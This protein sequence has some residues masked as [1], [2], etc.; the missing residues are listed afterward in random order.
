MKT[1]IPIST[2]A[3]DEPYLFDTLGQLYED[4]IVSFWAYIPHKGEGS[5]MSENKD[6]QHVYVELDEKVKLL[7]FKDYF[8][9]HDGTPFT[10]NWRKSD[11]QN[12][13]WYVLHDPAYLESKGIYREY[14]YSIDDFIVSDVREFDRLFNETEVPEPC[15]VRKAIMEGHSLKEMY[16]EGLLKPSNAVGLKIITECLKGEFEHDDNRS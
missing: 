11:F 3:Y 14:H 2:I 4:K 9:H 7:E 15:R 10:I 12:W 16:L 8:R 6:H 1:G 5:G 13:F